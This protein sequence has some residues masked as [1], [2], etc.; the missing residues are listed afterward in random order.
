MPI[1]KMH[2]EDGVFYTQTTG[3]FDNTDARMWLKAFQNYAAASD[4]PIIGV[5]DVRDAERLCSTIPKLLKDVLPH[6]NILHL[7]VTMGGSQ[8]RT[9]DKI[10]QMNKVKVVFT[11]EDAQRF[12]QTNV[13][14]S[15]GMNSSNAYSMYAVAVM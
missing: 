8:S 9:L 4:S 7:V 2:Y 13:R 14:P 12:A 15:F 5:I 11:A 6:G 10:V 1:H 3:Y